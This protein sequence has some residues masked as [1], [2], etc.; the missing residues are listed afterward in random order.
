MPTH[1]AMLRPKVY[2]GLAAAA[3]DPEVLDRVATAAG[4][5]IQDPATVSADLA[6]M[7]LVEA[8][9]AGLVSFDDLAGLLKRAEA[10]AVRVNSLRALGTLPA[11]KGLEEALGLALTDAVRAQ[12]LRRVF[13]PAWGGRS[14][15]Q[16]STL[17]FVRSRWD[18]V[19]RRLPTFG[20]GSAA[21]MPELVGNFCDE[22]GRDAA[23]KLFEDKVP[24]Q[25]VRH[26][27]LGLEKADQCIALRASQSIVFEA[28][29]EGTGGAA[30][31][32]RQ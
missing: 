1:D 22:T 30:K 24:N 2:A 14:A 11:G 9:R 20:W 6:T 26:L 19:T 28:S 13:G 21:R 7:V 16:M 23:R 8:A 25:G 27:K 5:Y 4:K 32:E 31:E 29:A 12:D 15:E 10:P 18:D 17:S 3:R